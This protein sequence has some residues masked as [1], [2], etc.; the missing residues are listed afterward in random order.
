MMTLGLVSGFLQAGNTGGCQSIL[1][2]ISTRIHTAFGQIFL[3][4]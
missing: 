3:D 4:I 2:K 1:M